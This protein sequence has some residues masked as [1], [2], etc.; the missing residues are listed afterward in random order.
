MTHEE[1]EAYGYG[2]EI[3]FKNL[4]EKIM[5]D[6][7]KRIKVA[8]ELSGSTTYLMEQLSYMGYSNKDIKRMIQE[9]LE[10]SEEYVDKLYDDVLQHEYL[11][12][13]PIFQ[14]KEVPMI[15]FKQN[16]VMQNLLS[17]AKNTTNNEM[18]NMTQ[19]LGFVK[20]TSDGTKAVELSKFYQE[21]M[22]KALMEVAT[23]TFSLDRALNDAV[24]TM[25][26][27]G[28]RWI[29]YES[30]H[31]NRIAV[32]ARRSVMSGLANASQEQTK[33]MAK[34]LDVHTF[35][36]SAHM[37]ARP[38]HAVWQGKVYTDEELVSVCGLGEV[39]GL[40][41]VNC[42]HN[43]YMFFEGVSKRTYTDEELERWKDDDPTEYE[44]K[45]YTNYEARQRIRQMETNMR[46]QKEKIKLLEK[47]GA[48]KEVIQSAQAR[49]RKQMSEYERFADAMNMKTQKNRITIGDGKT[50]KGVQATKVDE[51]FTPQSVFRA[52][53]KQREQF[54]R[55]KKVLGNSFDMPD[56]VEKF[57][58]KKYTDS[59]W[60]ADEKAKYR[61]INRYKVDYGEVSPEEILELDQI[62]LNAKDNMPNRKTRFD[63]NIGVLRTE[64]ETKIAHS[65][66]SNAND[67]TYINYEGNKNKLILSDE[68]NNYYKTAK[69]GE[70]VDGVP[71]S[72]D[73]YVDSEAKFFEYLRDKY[74]DKTSTFT[75]TIL[76]ERNMCQ[77]C[78][79]VYQQFIAEYPNA[80]V[81]VVS[82]KK[83]IIHKK[84]SDGSI[85]EKEVSPWIYRKR[86]KK[87]TKKKKKG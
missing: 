59:G 68:N 48:S 18:K 51:G 44:G 30:G 80:K 58:E 8:G 50:M 12:A 16:P 74:P 47:G 87:D 61:T 86:K 1:I 70:L 27:S 39:T 67:K 73:R 54:E 60:W 43:Y 57:L 3:I 36:V 17:F 10:E 32:A 78:R 35:E 63:G 42:Y 26:N 22:D 14:A 21:T 23:G 41:G 37:G 29:D 55:Y 46:A 75:I 71:S 45:E 82:G 19:S 83:T 52:N 84:N 66:I 72:N 49:Y 64:N 76:S 6:I 28:V 9:A 79:G 13:S 2:N 40:L 11:G 31:H 5:A 62:A 56:N 53:K 20:K 77:S 38:S 25:V 4:E 34:E 15:P 7:V 65:K 24:N 81:N 85:T 69:K 33:N